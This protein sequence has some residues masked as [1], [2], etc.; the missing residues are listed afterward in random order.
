MA[1]ALDIL[2]IPRWA[3]LIGSNSELVGPRI[4]AEDCVAIITLLMRTMKAPATAHLDNRI[5]QAA[6]AQTNALFIILSASPEPTN[7]CCAP[8]LDNEK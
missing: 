1:W 8:P 2:D 6:G 3:L 4:Q 5:A 7:T